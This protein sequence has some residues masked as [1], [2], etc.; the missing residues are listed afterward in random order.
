MQCPV[1]TSLRTRIHEGRERRKGKDSSKRDIWEE[2]K[3]KVRQCVPMIC[4]PSECKSWNLQT[5][6]GDRNKERGWEGEA[7]HQAATG[8]TSML[9]ARPIHP[10]EC[11]Q[12]MADQR[13]TSR[14]HSDKME[15]ASD[16]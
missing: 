8:S 9:V 15:W 2:P 3:S 11:S 5:G 14:A 16:R 10:A 6:W 12:L 7:Q 1:F 4:N 13:V